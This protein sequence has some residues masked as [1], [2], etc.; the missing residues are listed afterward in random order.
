VCFPPSQWAI[1]GRTLNY[2][3]TNN[4]GA[5]RLSMNCW[6]VPYH[7]WDEVVRQDKDCNHRDPEHEIANS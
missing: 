6:L 1:G 5:L 4:L 3:H 7:Y 2:S